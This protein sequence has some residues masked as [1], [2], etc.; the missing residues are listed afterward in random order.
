MGR[1]IDSD[2]ILQKETG[3]IIDYIGTSDIVI[4]PSCIDGI[5]IKK[6]GKFAFFNKNIK[7][8]TIANSIISIGEGAFWGCKKLL[9]VCIGN[10][11]DTIG[12]YVFKDCISLEG[13]IFNGNAPSD[14]G[15]EV[16]KNV[17]SSYKTFFYD[18]RDGFAYPYFKGHSSIKMI[19]T[20]SE[21]KSK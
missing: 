9:C 11:V 12:D 3:T 17:S 14:F 6:I 1:Y 19:I 4:I 7:N 20:N 18:S 10:R 16:F 8:V 2:Y 15:Y 13:A 5:P 21:A